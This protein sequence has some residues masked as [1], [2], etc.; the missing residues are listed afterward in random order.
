V[1]TRVRSSAA[2]YRYFNEISDTGSSTDWVNL[3]FEY[4]F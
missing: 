2:C 4:R 1:A 3:S